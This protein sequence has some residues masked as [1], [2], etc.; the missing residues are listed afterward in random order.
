MQTIDVS[1]IS[2]GPGKP[3][4]IIAGPCLAE[5][6]DLCMDVATSMRDC[7]A[8]L[9]LGYIFKASF[10]K[11]NRSSTD[12][13]RGPGLDEALDWFARIRQD[14]SVPV[15]TDIHQPTQAAI[16]GNVVDMIQIPAFLCRQT[17]LLVAAAETGKP[18]NAKKGQF[19]SPA[20]MR[21]VVG[22]LTDACSGKTPQIMLTERG[23][24]FGYGRLV[25]DFSGLDDMMALGWPVCFDVTHS[26]QQPGEAEGGKATGGRPQAAPTLARCAVAAGVQALFFETHPQPNKAL[27]DASVML[28]LESM[29]DLLADLAH[30]HAAVR[31]CSARD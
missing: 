21:N 18:V 30:L 14:V 11:A 26:T 19:M 22:K 7:C 17:D 1:D 9:G 3:L 12:S 13:H 6:L 4:A 31:T 16:V 23:T 10:D 24:F 27:C 28:P 15:T 29:P 5:S 2:I 25:N 8:K 20:E